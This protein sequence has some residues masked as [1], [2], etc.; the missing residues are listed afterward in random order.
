MKANRRL[1]KRT[2]PF[3]QYDVYLQ[4]ITPNFHLLL[5]AFPH[6]NETQ[7]C[8]WRV[9]VIDDPAGKGR[10]RARISFFNGFLPRLYKGFATR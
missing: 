10:K 1:R 9:T 8:L 7:T 4:L 5:I 6:Q 2:I 3:F